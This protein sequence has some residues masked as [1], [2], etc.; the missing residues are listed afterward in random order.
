MHSVH[1]C[2]EGH[3]GDVRD[4]KPLAGDIQHGSEWASLSWGSVPGAAI[5][6]VYVLD[7]LI[8]T[9][10][11]TRSCGRRSSPPASRQACRRQFL[12]SPED[13]TSQWSACWTPTT[14]AWRSQ[15][16]AS[17][18]H[19][20]DSQTRGCRNREQD[21]REVVNSRGMKRAR[22]KSAR[23]HRLWS[24][25][26]KS[27]PGAAHRASSANFLWLDLGRYNTP[28][29]EACCAASSAGQAEDVIATRWVQAGFT[30]LLGALCMRFHWQ[31]ECFRQNSCKRLRQR[32][33]GLK[34]AFG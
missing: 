14:D 23:G 5:T 4:R 10:M 32:S 7:S 24:L 20:G 27:S 12:S 29:H 17:P 19:R 33:D 31:R 2:T 11:A 1:D 34:A 8:A 13:N 25:A 30:R 15:V 16:I 3:L 6:L 26:C 18:F 21:L 22:L 9:S 28:V